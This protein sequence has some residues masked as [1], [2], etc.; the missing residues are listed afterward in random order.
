[1]EI[2]EGA[3]LDE[4]RYDQNFLNWLN[5]WGN[6]ILWLA[7]I[8]LGLYV[9]NQWLGKYQRGQV[10]KAFG[11]LQ[12]VMMLDPT[13]EAM[14][15]VASKHGD[16]RGIGAMA[17][18]GAA[19]QYLGAVRRGL[20]VGAI[21]APD[22]SLLTQDE[23][24]SE[25][26]RAFYLDQAE[27]QYR[28]VWEK[29]GGSGEMAIH[30]IGAGFGMAAVAETRGNV[31]QASEWY[32]NV[33]TLAAEHGFTDVAAHAVEMRE[34]LADLDLNPRLY[35]GE[36][37]ATPAEPDPPSDADI[38]EM[39]RRFQEEGGLEQLGGDGALEDDGTD[40]GADPGDPG[41]GDEN[42]SGGAEPDGPGGEDPPTD[43]GG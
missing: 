10:D 19:D 12:E 31:E 27:A 29:T 16:T 40:G 15:A 28:A 24:L 7:L 35:R 36:E 43:P 41:E 23:V 33:E 11:E 39:I 20:V 2:R 9:G 38:Q 14:L 3:G 25:E 1:M 4:N 8:A 37:L 30:A 32:T 5:K 17:R 22:G 42:G 6:R 34:G 13:P 18:L 26:D 21:L